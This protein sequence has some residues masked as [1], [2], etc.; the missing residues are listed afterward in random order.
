MA[1]YKKVDIGPYRHDLLKTTIVL[2]LILFDF[3]EKRIF[4]MILR[5]PDSLITFSYL[6]E[7]SNVQNFDSRFKVIFVYLL[8][9]LIYNIS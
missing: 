6:I 8:R 2:K 1:L 5:I 9:F 4:L 7:R 3:Y